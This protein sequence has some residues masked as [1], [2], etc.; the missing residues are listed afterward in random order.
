MTMFRVA[1]RLG[2]AGFPLLP[3]ALQ[4]LIHIDARHFSKFSMPLPVQA[5]ISACEKA[6]CFHEVDGGGL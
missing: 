5:A 4:L 1:T 2:A 6:G 3:G